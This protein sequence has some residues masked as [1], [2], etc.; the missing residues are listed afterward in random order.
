ML[1]DQR[2]GRYYQTRG[3]GDVTR[4]EAGEMLPDQTLSYPVQ[5]TKGYITN[6]TLSPKELWSNVAH[7]VTNMVP[8]GTLTQATVNP[9]LSTFLLYVSENRMSLFFTS[10]SV[11]MP[12]FTLSHVN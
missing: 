7:Y 12:V 6:A 8:F 11:L 4:P 3:W 1:P 10:S 5:H 2:L 9:L